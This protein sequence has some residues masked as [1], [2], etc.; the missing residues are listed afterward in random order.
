MGQMMDFLF[1]AIHSQGLAQSVLLFFIFFY[2]LRK[3][4]KNFIYGAI[5][6]PVFQILRLL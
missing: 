3:R 5:R 6:I 2:S 4:S 1:E